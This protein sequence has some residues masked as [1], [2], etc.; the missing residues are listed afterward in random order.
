MLDAAPA[1]YR[2]LDRDGQVAFK[3]GAK[4][5]VRTYVF[6]AALLPFN[7]PDWEKL[8]AFLSLLLPKL[9]SP[10]GVELGPDVLGAID[11]DGY[12]VEVS[13]A[14]RLMLPDENGEIGPVPT[15]TGR[16]QLEPILNFL[17]AVVREFNE[18]F[19]EVEFRDDERLRRFM[20]EEVP[21]RVLANPR[22]VNAMRSG[23]AQSDWVR[24]DR[25]VEAEVNDSLEDHMELYTRYR[26]EASFRAW[27]QEALFRLAGASATDI[28]TQGET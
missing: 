26:G 13:A 17:S 12:R 1:R 7:V 18:R 23:D 10:A 15:G 2:T 11:M 5:F 28:G 8:S 3:G 19:G 9:P 14:L 24:H 20:L 21:R 4:A 6:L 22:V 16:G 25:A 27:L